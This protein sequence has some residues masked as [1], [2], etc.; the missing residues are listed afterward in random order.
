MSDLAKV[1]AE[2][3]WGVPPEC[4]T[5]PSCGGALATYG[6]DIA[7][8]QVTELER[9]RPAR[10]PR[11]SSSVASRSASC[12]RPSR[13]SPRT[14]WSCSRTTSHTQGADNLAPIVR[15]DLLRALE[16]Q[17]IDLAAVLDPVS[18]AITTEDLTALNVRVGVNNEDLDVVAREYLISKG[19][20]LG[21]ADPRCWPVVAAPSFAPLAGRSPDGDRPSD[22]GRVT[23]RGQISPDRRRW[24][25]GQGPVAVTLSRSSR[26][27]PGMHALHARHR[28]GPHRPARPCRVSRECMGGGNRASQAQRDLRPQ[29]AAIRSHSPGALPRQCGYRHA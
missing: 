5:N 29:A 3:K 14:A 12:A 21:R 22:S 15:N 28:C 6:V 27:V 9:L 4:A 25:P 19:L 11:Q 24:D 8:M 7:G 16:A 13:R 20:L 17:G 18:A 26:I 1:A 2:L 23:V 10:W